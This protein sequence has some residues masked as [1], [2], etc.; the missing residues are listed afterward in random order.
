MY[1]ITNNRGNMDVVL[2]IVS[3]RK[4]KMKAQVCHQPR[5]FTVNSAFVTI[6]VALRQYLVADGACDKLAHQLQREHNRR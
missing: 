6:D 4:G 5:V 3:N 2:F 1:L